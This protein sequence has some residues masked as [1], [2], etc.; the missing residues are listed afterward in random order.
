MKNLILRIIM[1]S[2]LVMASVLDTFAADEDRVFRPITASDGLADN[3]AQ[4]MKCTKLGRMVITTMG[5]INFYSG[6]GFLHIPTSHELQYPIK[7]YKGHYHLYFDNQHHLWLKDYNVV[8]CLNLT[9]EYY[10][11]RVDSIFACNG[12]CG[13]VDDMFVDSN[14]DLW[15]CSEGFLISKKFGYKIRLSKSVEL[16]DVE[17]YYGRYLLMF[18]N[19][20]EMVCRDLKTGKKL[21]KTRAYDRKDAGKYNQTGVLHLCGNG[22][23]MIRNGE[24]EAILTSF[25][26][27]ERKWREIMRIDRHLNNMAMYDQKLYIAGEWG[28]YT[29][30]LATSE[31]KW[32]KT[33][34]TQSGR[35]LETSIN[36]IEFDKQGGMWIGTENR[37]VLY[38][39]PQDAPFYTLAW[40]N[41]LAVKYS[42]MMESKAKIDESKGMRP[43]MTLTDS[44]E[45]VWIGTP[46]GLFLYTSPQKAPQVFSSKNGLFNNVIHAIIEDDDHN[47]WVCTSYGISCLRIEGK[48]VKRVFSFNST[49]NVPNETFI[50]GHAMKLA[51]GTIVMQALDHMVYFN[52]RDFRALFNQKPYEM[53]LKLIRLLVNG[54]EVENG[55][56]MNG[57]AVIDRA[58]SRVREIN[59]NYD[60][61]S[62]SMTFSA[63]NFSRPLQT[64][65][66]VRVREKSAKW[67]EYN[68]FNS[69]GIVDGKGMFHLSLT[70]L[71]PGTYHVEIQATE[72]PGIFIGDHPYEWVINVRQP[73]WRTTAILFFFSSLVLVLSC[74]NAYVYSRNTKLRLKRNNQESEIIHRIAVFVER[75]DALGLELLTPS[76]DEIYGNESSSMTAISDHFIKVMVNN[77]IPF[78]HQHRNKEYSM[79]HLS[80]VAEMD[81]L[82]FYDLISENIYKSPRMLVLA[83]RIEKVEQLLRSSDFS[84]EDISK[85]CGFVS[86]NYMIAKFLHKY[87]L[88]PAEFRE[89]MDQ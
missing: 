64:N 70:G 28:Y 7:N 57:A 27:K 41:P 55:E 23:Y 5:N 47:V 81:L 53:S 58:V 19:T 59:L 52:P 22:F 38:D 75:T 46:R 20:G 13:K 72:V 60:Q 79:L 50:D 3:S 30:N 84:I 87:K 15:L 21:Y 69:K 18:Y 83:M 67:V 45:W 10:V 11:Q 43:G 71:E 9:T 31:I 86:A 26:L 63:L 33:I 56:K 49:D 8:S 48:K 76:E 37:G 1:A 65:Y 35:S 2:L 29:Y 78:V 44:R 74:Y 40:D 32:Y 61:N 88:T 80:K 14:G 25:D 16:Q 73:W 77:I 36:T 54:I 51:N 82:E 68:Y 6:S 17:T 85:E 4:T 34:K 66:R 62:I 42:E 89:K 39:R 24:K 12:A